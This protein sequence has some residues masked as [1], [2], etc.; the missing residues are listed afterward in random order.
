MATPYAL[1]TVLRNNQNGMLRGVLIQIRDGEPA[2]DLDDDGS[3]FPEEIGDRLGWVHRN[4]AGELLRVDLIEPC[5]LK[6]LL[7]IAGM[8]L[9]AADYLVAA[10]PAEMIAAS[11]V[12]TFEPDRR[13]RPDD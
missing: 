7:G 2:Y 11:A 3:P 1:R 8:D 4:L 10:I 13:T 9:A 6:T 5:P 12:T